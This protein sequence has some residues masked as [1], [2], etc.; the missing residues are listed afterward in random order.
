MNWNDDSSL[1]YSSDVMTQ[2]SEQ[3]AISSLLAEWP[4]IEPLESE[5]QQRA[6][7]EHDAESEYVQQRRREEEALLFVTIEGR[8]GLC[9]EAFDAVLSNRF[10]ILN[11]SGVHVMKYSEE[12]RAQRKLWKANTVD[13]LAD[14]EIVARRA[15]SDQPKLWNI[16]KE[17]VLENEGE[18]W[19]SP[20]RTTQ[21]QISR[22]VAAAYRKAGLFPVHRYFA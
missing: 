18:G 4:E 14:A 17:V 1:D 19:D 7:A 5:E 13:F 3:E 8:F 9:D 15:L 20:P 12:A 16:V 6:Q 22:P 10:D 11:R 2:Y 21:D